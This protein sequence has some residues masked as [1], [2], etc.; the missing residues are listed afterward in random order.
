VVSVA[1]QFH[2]IEA[3]SGEYDGG[4][5]MKTI[6]SCRIAKQLHLSFCHI[7]Q[8]SFLRIPQKTEKNGEKFGFRQFSPET[9]DEESLNCFSEDRRGKSPKRHVNLPQTSITS[10]S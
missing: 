7:C 6:N 10:C 8:E 3:N 1:I 2:E 4:Y 9:P 5:L